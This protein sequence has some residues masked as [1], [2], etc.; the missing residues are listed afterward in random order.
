MLHP[1]GPGLHR[2]CR[3]VALSRALLWQGAPRVVVASSDGEIA[4][5]LDLTNSMGHMPADMYLLEMKRVRTNVWR[6]GRSTRS[7]S[8]HHVDDRDLVLLASLGY[9]HHVICRAAHTP[10][11]CMAVAGLQ[12]ARLAEAAQRQAEESQVSALL[13]AGGGIAHGALRNEK[14]LRTLVEL[15]RR[16]DAQRLAK[17]SRVQRW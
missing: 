5:G 4:D 12:V 17:K 9:L 8:A 7:V 3:G 14:T 10:D 2:L 1:L 13:L 11:A 15:R 6:V 16:L